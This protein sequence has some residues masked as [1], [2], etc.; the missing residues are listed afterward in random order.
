[1]SNDDK[2]ILKR[3]VKTDGAACPITGCSLCPLVKLGVPLGLGRY[4]QELGGIP[5]T[6]ENTIRRAKKILGLTGKKDMIEE[7]MK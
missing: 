4:S 3:M 6:H 7:I 1:M 2:D 5:C